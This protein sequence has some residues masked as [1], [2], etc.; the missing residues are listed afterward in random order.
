LG[1]KVGIALQSDIPGL[2]GEQEFEIIL[3]KFF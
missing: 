3:F 2:K 1:S